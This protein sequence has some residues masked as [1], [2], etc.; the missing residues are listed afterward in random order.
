MIKRLRVLSEWGLTLFQMRSKTSTP[1][2]TFLRTRPISSWNQFSGSELGR[3]RGGPLL[4]VLET[5]GF[6]EDLGRR[7]TSG[8]ER[9]RRVRVRL[10]IWRFLVPDTKEKVWGRVLM[11]KM[12]GFW[13]RGRGSGSFA[14]GV[15]DHAAETVEEDG[16]LTTVDCV[17]GGVEGGRRSRTWPARLRGRGGLEIDSM[18]P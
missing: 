7:L 14:D 4:V 15:V 1:L 17:E 16:A 12:Y 9:T 18:K 3:W 6:K 5:Q 8:R 10:T 13:S 11:S 2:W